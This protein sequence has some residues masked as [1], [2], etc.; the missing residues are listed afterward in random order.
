LLSFVYNT[1]HKIRHDNIYLIVH[2]C[3]LISF[4][5]LGFAFVA[6]TPWIQ[7]GT[8]KDNILFGQNYSVEKYK[9]YLLIFVIYYFISYINK[10][11]YYL[12]IRMVIKCCALVKDLQEFPR[13][14]LTLIGEAGITLSGGQKARLALARAVYQVLIKNNNKCNIFFIL[15]KLFILFT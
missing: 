4:T 7:K 14:D 1:R 9:Y 2:I 11:Y 15:E 3:I 10:Y 5:F 12:F 13:G 8:I 6:Q